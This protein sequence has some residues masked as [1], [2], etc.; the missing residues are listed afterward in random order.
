[1]APDVANSLDPLAALAE[2]VRRRLYEY[3]A[4]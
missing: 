3:V 2:P 4:A 1:M